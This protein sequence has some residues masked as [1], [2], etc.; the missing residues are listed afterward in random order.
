MDGGT[1]GARHLNKRLR[2]YE[3]MGIDKDRGRMGIEMERG[4]W[5]EKRCGKEK[6]S[7]TVAFS[8]LLHNL[9][10]L[11]FVAFVFAVF[12]PLLNFPNSINLTLTF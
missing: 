7:L 10:C 9:H 1:K 5:N 4:R 12:Y 3:R 6:G 11:C 8:D 2:I